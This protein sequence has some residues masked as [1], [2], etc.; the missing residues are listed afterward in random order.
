MKA[1]E[2]KTIDITTLVWFDKTYGNSYFAQEITLNYGLSN[3]EVHKNPFQYGYDSYQYEA[4][5]FLGKKVF[6]EF[7][8]SKIHEFFKF[9]DENKIIIRSNTHRNCKKRE[10]IN[11]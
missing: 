1:K 6:S 2:L 3:A 10:L 8:E 5:D 7:K 11:I 9:C 4:L